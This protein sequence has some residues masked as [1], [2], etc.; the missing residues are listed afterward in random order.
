MWRFGHSGLA[1][2]KRSFRR[3]EHLAGKRPSRQSL[4]VAQVYMISGAGFRGR[5]ATGSR[6]KVTRTGCLG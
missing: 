4:Y 6:I 1:F 3:V 2:C 5:V